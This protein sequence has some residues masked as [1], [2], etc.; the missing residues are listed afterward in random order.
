M[1]RYCPLES[2]PGGGRALLVL[3]GEDDSVENRVLRIPPGLT[4]SAIAQATNFLN[5]HLRGLTLAKARARI[6]ERAA[7]ARRE[8]DALAARL[9][10]IARRNGRARMSAPGARR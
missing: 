8:L 5:G 9:V 10:E 3:V 1:W 2:G 6:T 7:E 4:P